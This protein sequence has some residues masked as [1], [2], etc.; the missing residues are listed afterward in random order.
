MIPVEAFL[1]AF[2]NANI[3]ICVA[4]FLWIGVR[5][6]LKAIGLRQAYGVQ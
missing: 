2:V 4:Y 3:L 1:D 6:L 5:E